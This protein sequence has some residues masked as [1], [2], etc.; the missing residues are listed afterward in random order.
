MICLVN[1]TSRVGAAGTL[2][3]ES[4]RQNDTTLPDDFEET[5]QS[6]AGDGVLTSGSTRVSEENL[7]DEVEEPLDKYLFDLGSIG[8][9]SNVN[10]VTHDGDSFGNSSDGASSLG[11]GSKD[12]CDEHSLGEFMLS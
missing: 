10:S 6:E 9:R 3:A 12:G 1:T 4:S 8:D 11:G 2:N 5:G 7:G